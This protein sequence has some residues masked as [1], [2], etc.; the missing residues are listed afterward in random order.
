MSDETPREPLPP[1]RLRF[2]ALLPSA[3]GLALAPRDDLEEEE[4]TG[5]LPAKIEA[6]RREAPQLWAELESLAPL[7][8]EM[9][10]RNE[11]RYQTW[12]LQDFLVRK[13]R[14]TTP[15]DADEALEL[16]QLALVLVDRLA[17]RLGPVLEAECRAT[18]LAAEAGVMRREGFLRE[19]EAILEEAFEVLRDSQDLFVESRLL[20]DRG[21]IATDQGRLHVAAAAFGRSARLLERLGNSHMAARVRL[22]QADAVGPYDPARAIVILRRALPRLD[23]AAEPRLELLARHRLIWFV[24]DVGRPWMAA[25]L[26]DDARDLYER[27]GDALVRLHR[28]WLEGRIL[29]DSGEIEAADRILNRAY[30]IF[31]EI[32]HAQDLV[33][34]AL[35]LV[36]LYRI[37]GAEQRAE[38]LVEKFGEIFE[39]WRFHPDALALWRRAL[40]L[41]SHEQFAHLALLVRENWPRLTADAEPS[42]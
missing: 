35:D 3:A 34:C 37:A 41:D 18:A 31:A 12:G 36:A 38:R 15:E 24:N 21:E 39:R 29:R 6:E 14:A 26:L 27:Y 17:P 30:R 13:A 11:R 10:V 4:T 28:L 25:R 22:Q 16:T 8:R 1:W 7:R 32:G 19:A 42:E 40:T 2:S 20:I 33:L 5:G 23:L 9:L